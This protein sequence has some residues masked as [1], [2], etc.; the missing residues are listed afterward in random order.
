MSW[1]TALAAGLATST[2]YLLYEPTSSLVGEILGS[3]GSPISAMLS[4]FYD[5]I[6]LFDEV[7]QS[8][9]ILPREQTLGM[10]YTEHSSAV[11][12]P[13]GDSFELDF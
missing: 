11:A 1:S 5:L 4:H 13:A 9:P 6:Q 12:L 7:V 2:A 3:V 8:L 10:H